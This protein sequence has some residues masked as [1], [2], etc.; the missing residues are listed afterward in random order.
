MPNSNSSSM[1]ELNIK[2][3]ENKPYDNYNQ[4]KPVKN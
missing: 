4:I 2:D 3:I 1:V